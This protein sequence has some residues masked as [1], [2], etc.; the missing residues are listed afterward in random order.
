[1]LFAQS[2]F[3]GRQGV[4]LEEAGILEYKLSHKSA[5]SAR[6]STSVISSMVASL[7]RQ[8]DESYVLFKYIT[9]QKFW[10]CVSVPI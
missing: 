6:V 2:L 4:R 9:C 5:W 3:T 8:H 10:F 7:T 1:M